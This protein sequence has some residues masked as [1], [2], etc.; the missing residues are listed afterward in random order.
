MTCITDDEARA[1]A[2]TLSP[3][4]A[5]DRNDIGDGWLWAPLADRGYITVQMVDRATADPRPT[6]RDTGRPDQIR[7]ALHAYVRHH[8]VRGP[9]EGWSS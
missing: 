3:P 4:R 7:T 2:A 9:V 8:G 1:F 6:Y 5:L